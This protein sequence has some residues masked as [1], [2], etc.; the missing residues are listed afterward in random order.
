LRTDC[1]IDNGLSCIAGVDSLAPLPESE[2]IFGIPA[3]VGDLE[4]VEDCDGATDL[5][6]TLGCKAGWE[7][8]LLPTDPVSDAPSSSVLPWLRR[9]KDSVDLVRL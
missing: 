6:D 3:I 8:E 1:S 7:K 4:C 5:L 9:N 2:A